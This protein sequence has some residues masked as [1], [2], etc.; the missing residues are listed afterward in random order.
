M[1][2][3]SEDSKSTRGL[4]VTVVVATIILSLYRMLD[5]NLTLIFGLSVGIALLIIIFTGRSPLWVILLPALFVINQALDDS[6]SNLV[7]AEVVAR[8]APFK[9]TSEVSIKLL[10]KNSIKTL[11]GK[12]SEFKF[13]IG[14]RDPQIPTSGNSY[15]D[16]YQARTVTPSLV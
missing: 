7:I 12:R 2:A 3:S 1:K 8:S 16:K 14:P 4:I 6:P 11:I 15:H 10:Q 5:E 13:S 9:G